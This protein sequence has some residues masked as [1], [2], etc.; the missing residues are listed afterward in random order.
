VGAAC[1]D[2]S[3][4]PLKCE[5][6]CGAG[7]ACE[8]GSCRPVPAITCNPVCGPCSTCDSTGA[9]PICV[10]LCGTGTT[11]NAATKRCEPRA[12]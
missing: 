7:Q 8:N 11:C 12:C 10:D 6:A 9:A 3:C 5:P 4:V 2:G 1:V